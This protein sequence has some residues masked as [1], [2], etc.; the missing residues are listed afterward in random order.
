MNTITFQSDEPLLSRIKSLNYGL[1]FLV[2]LAGFIGFLCLYSAGG[3]NVNPWA[4]PH[5]VR[6]FLGFAMMIGVA[7]IDIRWWYKMAWPIYILG[8]VLLI[9]V[10]IMG[11]VGMGAQRWIDLG[12]IKIQ[13]SELMKLA[14]VMAMA[15][16]FHGAEPDQVKRIFFLI[17]AALIAL[18][19]VGLVLLQ[20]NLG[21]S[22]MILM[23]GAAMFLMAGVPLWMF[24]V[25]IVAGLSA[26]PVVWSLMHDY[27]KQR[28]LTFLDPESDPLG[29][30]YHITQSKIALGSGGI[31][32]KGFLQGTQSHLNFLPEKQTDF[33]FTLWA[34]EWGFMGGVFLLG[35]FGLIF[36]YGL[37]IAFRC[38]HNFGRYLALGLSVNFSLYIFINTAM[39]M[40]LIPV[41]GIPMPLISYGGTAMLAAMIGF[42]LMM[43][44]SVYRDSKLSRP[45]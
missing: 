3:G 16:Y 36:M 23:N 35:L 18:A 26:V 21:T 27:Q 12:I 24:G 5:V 2:T 34:E 11:H 19:P 15:R 4:M 29:S 7:L 17:P 38:R 30:G 41:V 22:L 33:I 20:P 43:S 14:V 25:V 45:G 10:E 39:V 9:I 28:V 6:F 31:D 40:G 44:C 8:F 37:Y 1:I 13:P 32:G 42:G